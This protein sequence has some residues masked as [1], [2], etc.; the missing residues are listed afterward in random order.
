MPRDDAA[1]DD[2]NDERLTVIGVQLQE[3]IRGF[4]AV[5]DVELKELRLQDSHIAKAMNEV[6][7]ALAVLSRQIFQVE[8]ELQTDS[9]GE[10]LR[11][12]LRLA[13]VKI[14]TLEKSAEILES[15]RWEMRL[16]LL[17]NFVAIALAI[18]SIIFARK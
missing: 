9:A 5:R 15:R 1:R 10:G 6:S 18:V 7:E 2:R 3:L 14:A 13:E 16:A 11:S 17:G 4:N 8:K 12:R